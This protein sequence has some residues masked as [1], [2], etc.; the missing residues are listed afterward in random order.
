MAT[1]DPGAALSP[2][3]VE[4]SRS[5]MTALRRM[6]MRVE[7]P[8]DPAWLRAAPTALATM[9]RRAQ[10]MIFVLVPV[11]GAYTAYHVYSAANGDHFSV[12]SAVLGALLTV[13]F[14]TTAVRIRR[15]VT[16]MRARLAVGS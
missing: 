4:L 9:W 12:L 10:V 8:A 5:D 11:L 2:D 7:L 6:L 15:A 13:L 1:F 3:T 16:Q 14:L